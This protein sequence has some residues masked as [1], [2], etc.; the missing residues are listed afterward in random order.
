MYKVKTQYVHLLNIADTSI[1]RKSLTSI[2][3]H[4]KTLYVNMFDT[5]DT[6]FSYK[7][8]L[9]VWSFLQ[10]FSKGKGSNMQ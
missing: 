4:S 9:I 6:T 5:E 10:D 8:E 2:H 7:I 1:K 3:S